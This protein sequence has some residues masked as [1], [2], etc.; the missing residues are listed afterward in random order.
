MAIYEPSPTP[1]DFSN[2]RTWA[3]QQLRRVADVLR[4]P[5]VQGVHFDTLHVEPARRS[6]GD[7]VLADGTDWNPGAGAGLYIRLSGTWVKL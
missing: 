5:T 6:D 1:Y 2:F 7:I 3:A 4:T